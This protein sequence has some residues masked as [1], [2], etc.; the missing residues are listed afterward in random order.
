MINRDEI[1]PLKRNFQDSTV[2]I[3]IS[4]KLRDYTLK[5]IAQVTKFHKFEVEFYKRI[6]K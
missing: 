1:A 6:I 5:I 4:T 3:I 2:P